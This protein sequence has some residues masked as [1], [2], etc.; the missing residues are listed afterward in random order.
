[1][2]RD[3]LGSCLSFLDLFSINL[4][5]SIK[6]L[7]INQTQSIY[8]SQP[9]YY[10]IQHTMMSQSIIKYLDRHYGQHQ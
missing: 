8:H 9:K 7:Y 2:R 6:L 1:M 4:H 10:H 5:N 3:T